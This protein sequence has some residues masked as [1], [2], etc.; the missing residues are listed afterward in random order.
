MAQKVIRNYEISC[1]K[2]VNWTTGGSNRLQTLLEQI[3][4]ISGRSQVR[5]I[6]CMEKDV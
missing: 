6:W 3:V 5:L 4:I 1:K 2:G